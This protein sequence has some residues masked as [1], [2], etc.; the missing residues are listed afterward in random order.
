MVSEGVRIDSPIAEG[1]VLAVKKRLSAF[2]TRQ[3]N[4][5]LLTDEEAELAGGRVPYG[6]LEEDKALPKEENAPHER[7]VVSLPPLGRLAGHAGAADEPKDEGDGGGYQ[8]YPDAGGPALR[9]H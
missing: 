7:P 6:L 5:M 2:G 1:E 9:S 4:D 3:S 8:S